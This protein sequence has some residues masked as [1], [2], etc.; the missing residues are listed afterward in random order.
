MM[1]LG[2]RMQCGGTCFLG[3]ILRAPKIDREVFRKIFAIIN[4]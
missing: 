1:G 4:V 2:D 3:T